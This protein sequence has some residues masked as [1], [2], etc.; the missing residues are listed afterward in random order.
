M[1][2]SSRKTTKS[3]PSSRKKSG[4]AARKGA[5]AK[6]AQAP[7]AKRAG[8]A[9]KTSAKATPSAGRRASSSPSPSSST[10][11][12]AAK[13][14]AK[15][16]T[17]RRQQEKP[18]GAKGTAKPRT[19]AT[20]PK[21][22]SATVTTNAAAPK[23]PASSTLLLSRIRSITESIA[24]MRDEM[25]SLSKAVASNKD[26]TPAISGMSESLAAVLVQIQKQSRQITS[27][28]KET[29]GLF[30]GLEEI[31]DRSES[32]R[33]SLESRLH[34]VQ[35]KIEKIAEVQG[36]ADSEAVAERINDSVRSIIED[37]ESIAGLSRALDATRNEIR[38]VGARAASATGTGIEIDA[39]RTE[40]SGI[41]D[42]VNA[43][44][45]SSTHLKQELDRLADRVETVAKSSSG[46]QE[47]IRETLGQVAAETAKIKDVDAVLDGFKSQL[48]A[49]TSKT[50]SA[51]RIEIPE[52]VTDRLESIG[53]KIATLAKSADEAALTK[54]S[55]DRVRE[56]IV[57]VKSDIAGIIGIMDQKMSSA[58]GILQRQQE[59]AAD[60]YGKIDEMYSRIQEIKGS[61]DESAREASKETARLL[62]LSEY[63]SAMR[64]SSES[65]YGNLDT[66][67]EMSAKTADINEVFGG[68]SGDD[69]D[70]PGG[71]P[72]DVRRWAASKIL[73]CADRWEIRFADVYSIMNE[74]MGADM[75]RESINTSQVRDIY[76]IRAVNE[77]NGEAGSA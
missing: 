51:A 6:R 33:G 8:S 20:K 42:A 52:S 67:R 76:G 21:T 26:R 29:Q 68:G 35:Q 2:T 63:Q 1:A 59:N 55:L 30:E 3:S 58:S 70:G 65:K 10:P 34:D 54:D 15:S 23:T 60:L 19:S 57:S 28:K 64:M 27:L 13:K 32:K 72:P 45:A 22:A 4:A 36:Q 61:S 9:K 48:D 62:R 66:I 5:G 69:N 77:I 11:P 39:L 14:P 12:S 7:A 71:L 31:S 73:D 44:S 37:S 49:I 24:G 43:G 53:S 17:A 50:E 40:I 47:G 46:V 16:K 18:K 56:E 25:Q 75:V 74:M 41:A 38:V